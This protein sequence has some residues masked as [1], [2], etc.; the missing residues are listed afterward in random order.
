L[1]AEAAILQ[2]LSAR[3]EIAEVVVRYTRAIDR[4]EEQLLRSCFHPDSTHDHGGF[5]GSSSDFCRVAMDFVSKLVETQHLLG[6]ISVTVDGE[7]ATAESYFSAY[8]RMPATGDMVF[9]DA[10]PNDDV[11]VGGRNKDRF[12]RRNGVWL[13]SHRTGLNEWWRFEAACD[14]GNFRSA[15]TP[16]LARTAE[17]H[18]LRNQ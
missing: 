14:R 13:I 1:S 9:P 11:F 3:A 2:T 16:P 15:K 10:N 6:N 12:E 8:H 4:R 18:G 5:T 7:K 17:A